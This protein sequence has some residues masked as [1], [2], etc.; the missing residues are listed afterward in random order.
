MVLVMLATGRQKYFGRYTKG[1]SASASAL[2]I[3]KNA[4]VVV[5]KTK[6]MFNT[7]VEQ[8]HANIGELRRIISKFGGERLGGL[9]FSV[10]LHPANAPT[11][12]PVDRLHPKS[13]KAILTRGDPGTIL[14]VARLQAIL[15]LSKM[16]RAMQRGEGK[17]TPSNSD[18]HK[19]SDIVSLSE[20]HPCSIV[21]P[22]PLGVR[23]SFTTI[24]YS[25]AF[26][27]E[28]PTLRIR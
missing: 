7:Q 6:T 25:K 27:L 24:S 15:T 11:N 14:I 5:T 26:V 3:G 2:G 17:T 16:P 23:Y 9:P 10:W 21:P 28:S 1:Y 20:R 22:P 4:H 19:I 8:F 12:H 13:R 18:S